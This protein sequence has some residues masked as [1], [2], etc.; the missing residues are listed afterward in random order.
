MVRERYGVEKIDH[1]FS[2]A[3]DL[4]RIVEIALN[5]A[6]ISAADDLAADRVAIRDAIAGIQGYEGLASGPISFC[7]SASIKMRVPS[8]RQPQGFIR[9]LF[10]RAI[11]ARI[12]LFPSGKPVQMHGAISTFMA[13]IHRLS[14]SIRSCPG[15]FCRL[16]RSRTIP[17]LDAARASCSGWWLPPETSHEPERHSGKATAA[18]IDVSP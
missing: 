14:R 9:P 8:W 3:W 12:V 10:R 16:R 11:A 6:D 13:G 15:A 7:S 2:Q 4:I 17:A 1:D 18:M 5:N